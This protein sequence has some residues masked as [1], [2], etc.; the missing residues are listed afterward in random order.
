MDTC[1]GCK[2]LY[3]V[4]DEAGGGLWK[5]RKFRS[6]VVGEWGHWVRDDGEP[7]P[8]RNNCKEEVETDGT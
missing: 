4:E 8:I 6:A 7:K 5:C 2:F 1:F 3:D